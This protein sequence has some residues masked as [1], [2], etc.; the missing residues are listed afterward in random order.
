MFVHYLVY[1]PVSCVYNSGVMFWKQLGGLLCD[2]DKPSLARR[3]VINYS[4][5]YRVSKQGR[6]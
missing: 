3:V 6:Y 4:A 2:H 5:V 1:V